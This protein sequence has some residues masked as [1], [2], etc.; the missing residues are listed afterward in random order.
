MG[1]TGRGGVAAPRPAPARP[2]LRLRTLRVAVGAGCGNSQAHLTRGTLL[3]RRLKEAAVAP[4]PGRGVPALSGSLGSGCHSRWDPALPGWRAGLPWGKQKGPSC[5]PCV[6][7]GPGRAAH[8][9]SWQM[10]SEGSWHASCQAPSPVPCPLGH[11]PLPLGFE[12]LPEVKAPASMPAVGDI[13]QF[14]EGTCRLGQAK[15]VTVESHGGRGSGS[16]ALK[17][18]LSL[19]LPAGSC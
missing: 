9:E 3:G 1:S 4:P 15:P 12:N 6:P 10:S 16:P 2:A 14:S 11:H 19:L 17:S 18:T 7:S 8:P 5:W 13:A